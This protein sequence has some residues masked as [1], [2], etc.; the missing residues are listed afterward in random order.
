MRQFW[1]R[2]GFV[3]GFGIYART[4]W[5]MPRLQEY[6]EALEEYRRELQEELRA[7][8]EELALL[9]RVQEGERKSE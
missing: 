7:V 6:I 2:W 8:D 9:R 1:F 3:P 5:R 4:F